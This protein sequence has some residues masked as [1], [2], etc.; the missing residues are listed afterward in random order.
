MCDEAMC[1]PRE[2]AVMTW[3]PWGLPYF[4]FGPKHARKSEAPSR[5][6]RVSVCSVLCVGIIFLLSQGV[7]IPTKTKRT[8]D[9]GTCVASYDAVP[10]HT[11]NRYTMAKYLEIL[12]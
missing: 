1:P 11:N 9:N 8:F 6:S 4:S 5:E 3:L 10:W 12:H 2:H 7:V